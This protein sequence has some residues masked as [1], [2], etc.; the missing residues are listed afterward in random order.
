MVNKQ[1]ILMALLISMGGLIF[2]YDTGSISGFLQMPDYLD[3]F[4][5]LHDVHGHS[6]FSV[7]RAGLTVSIVS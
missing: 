1:V 5:D 4:G 2:G 7:T 3:R 6:V